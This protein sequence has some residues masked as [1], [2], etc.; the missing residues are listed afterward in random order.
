MT[1][2]TCES[3]IDARG[4]GRR[5][6]LLLLLLTRATFFG[7]GLRSLFGRSEFL[8]VQHVVLVG[9]GAIEDQRRTIDELVLA[10][11]AVAVGIELSAV[12]FAA[13]VL[14]AALSQTFRHVVTIEITIRVAIEPGEL[15]AAGSDEFVLGHR[16]IVVGVGAFKHSFTPVSHSLRHR[17]RAEQAEQGSGGKQA[18]HR[19]VSLRVSR[20]GDNAASSPRL[21][22]CAMLRAS[23]REGSK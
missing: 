20:A 19:V 11:L 13:A 3:P 1:A 17:G 22:G 12:H 18:A 15:L 9:I 16:A 6:L 4:A 10:D 8:R 2:R 23:E 14:F 7:G 5:R 21:T